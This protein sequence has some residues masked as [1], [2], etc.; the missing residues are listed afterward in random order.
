MLAESE[1]MQTIPAVQRMSSDYPTGT[2]RFG[3]VSQIIL[4]LILR[5]TWWQHKKPLWGRMYNNANVFTY[6]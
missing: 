6:R 3:G 2:T 4:L 1:G 5:E